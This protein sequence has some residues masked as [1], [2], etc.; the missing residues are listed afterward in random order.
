MYRRLFPGLSAGPNGGLRHGGSLQGTPLNNSG[1]PEPVAYS[2]LAKVGAPQAS[3]K[4]KL[5]SHRVLNP[6]LTGEQRGPET[7]LAAL[8]RTTCLSGWHA[9]GLL[10][11]LESEMHTRHCRQQSPALAIAGTASGSLAGLSLRRSYGRSDALRMFPS[12]LHGA[13]GLDLEK[14]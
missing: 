14:Q 3:C 5:L 9:L 12:A 6:L 8:V 2:S 13:R 7:G 1:C 10:V 11:L 4:T